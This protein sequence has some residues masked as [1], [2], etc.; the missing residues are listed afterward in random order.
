MRVLLRMVMA[1][2]LAYGTVGVVGVGAT[3]AEPAPA[4]Q[5]CAGYPCLMSF[6]ELDAWSPASVDPRQR[7]SVPLAARPEP[8]TPKVVVGLDLTDFNYS[9]LADGST[10]GGP[11]DNLYAFNHWQ[12]ADIAYYFK[13]S[14]VSVPPVVW[15]NAAHRNGVQMLGVIEADFTGGGDQF[16]DL[17]TDEHVERTT[18]QLAT[19]ASAFGFDGWLFDPENGAEPN[20]NMVGSIAAL[21]SQ[22]FVV[23]YY[24]AEVC[25]LGDAPEVSLDAANAATFWQSDYPCMTADAPEG[26][27][28][29][30]TS[31]AGGLDRWDAYNASSLYASEQQ[32]A[33]PPC[34]PGQATNGVACNRLGSLDVPDAQTFFGKLAFDVSQTAPGGFWGSLAVYA[35]SWPAYGGSSGFPTR[36]PLDVWRPLDDRIWNG[37]TAPVGPDCSTAASD[38]IARFVPPRPPIASLPFTTTFNRGFGA[39]FSVSGLPVPTTGW[40]HIGMETALPSWFCR[41]AGTPGAVEVALVDGATWT[42]GT[43]LALTGALPAGEEAEW[44]LWAAALPVP[45][46]GDDEPVAQLR[47]SGSG[48]AP[49]L[50]LRFADG[51][52]ERVPLQVGLPDTNGWRLAEASLGPFAGRTLTQVGLGVEGGPDTASVALRVGEVTLALGDQLAPPGLV[53]P[54]LASGVLTWDQPPG[55][56]AANVWARVETGCVA[57]LGPAY[58]GTYDTAQA[59]FSPP[60]GTT[61]TGYV[62]QPVNAAGAVATLGEPRC[63]EPPVPPSPDVVPAADVVPKF[64]G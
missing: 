18:E 51:G 5:D 8:P 28:D 56:V 6:A 4:S 12:Q 7:V 64:A 1:M 10:Q 62:V 34:A 38:G 60:A 14:L 61:V 30:L 44:A 42:G 55:A 48:P 57:L 50:A 45:A 15:T 27:Y 21:R 3:Q 36:A 37:S 54:G 2:V 29:Q 31:Q 22:G 17:F 9:P 20:Q 35:P 16:N 24:E 52:T 41:T 46:A 13:H 33:S 32:G 49:W 26:T 63:G 47:I 40:N 23:G 59:L 58:V 53:D 43:A 11:I 39:S 25:D 19:M